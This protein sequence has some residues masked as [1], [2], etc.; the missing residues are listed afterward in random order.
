VKVAR[1]EVAAPDRRRAKLAAP[2]EKAAWLDP[3]ALDVGISKLARKVLLAAAKPDA[4]SSIRG[5]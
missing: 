5:G 1:A 4:G 3:G 2:Y